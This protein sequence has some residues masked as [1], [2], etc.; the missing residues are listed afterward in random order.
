MATDAEALLFPAK[1]FAAA[2][3]SY[4]VSLSIGFSRARGAPMSRWRGQQF[5]ELPLIRRLD[6]EDIDQRN[7]LAAR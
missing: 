5:N 2:M 4:Y 1:C 3:I 7:K 6:S